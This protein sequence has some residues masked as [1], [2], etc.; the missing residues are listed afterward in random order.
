MHRKTII[1]IAAGIAV[2][3][4]LALAVLAFVSTHYFSAGW[5]DQKPFPL[6]GIELAPPASANGIEYFGKLRLD[7]YINTDGGVDR[8]EASESTVPL[9][10][11]DDAIRA[12]S[13]ARWEPGR[14]W[15]FRVRSVKR[16]EIDLEPPQGVR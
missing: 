4:G 2:A 15:G 12:F 1:R 9:R 11:R 7:V 5:L 3:A 14:K 8:V 10:L 13:T 16:V 6:R